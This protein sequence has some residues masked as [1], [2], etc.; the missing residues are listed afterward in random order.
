MHQSVEVVTPIAKVISTTTLT[1]TEKLILSDKSIE[2]E[3]KN[4][5][6]HSFKILTCVDLLPYNGESSFSNT[7]AAFC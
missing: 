1:P 6:L 2:Q 5:P 7:G 4:D 3:E